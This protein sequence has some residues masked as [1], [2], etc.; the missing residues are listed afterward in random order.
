[1][2][3]INSAQIA[4]AKFFPQRICGVRRHVALNDDVA[5]SAV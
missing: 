4:G 5:A 3:E 2:L 1:M